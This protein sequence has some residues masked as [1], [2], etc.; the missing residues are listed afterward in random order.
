MT[1]NHSVR[2]RHNL[3]WLDPAAC[4]ERD[5]NVTAPAFGGEIRRWKDL[6]WPV[7]VRRC[8]AD[9]PEDKACLGVTL[10]LSRDRA[11]VAVRVSLRAILRVEPPCSLERVIPSAP[12][13]WQPRLRSLGRRS[14]DLDISFG[15]FGSLS[16]QH[17]TGE[18]YLK[19]SSDV[20]LLFRPTDVRQLGEGL[21]LLR[22]WEEDTGLHADGEVLLSDGSGVAWRE[23]LRPHDDVLVKEMSAVRLRPV[24]EVMQ[25]LSSG[26]VPRSRTTARGG[27]LY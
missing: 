4:Y 22:E 15:V 14:A 21:R 2:L 3:V 27:G 1:L 6:G 17:L 11:R 26:L 23:L 13:S 25:D 8:Q 19:P 12:P 20:D 10:P 9:E 16:W 5:I 7:V 24:D 18:R